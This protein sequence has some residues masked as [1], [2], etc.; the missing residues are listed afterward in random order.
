MKIDERHSSR[1]RTIAITTLGCKVNQC[2]SAAIADELQKSGYEL[3]PFNSRADCYIINTCVVTASTESQSRQ[4]IR[5]A[6][7]HS[8]SAEV[9]VTGCYAQHRAE[10]LRVLFPRIKIA[11]NAEKKDLAHTIHCLLNGGQ[12]SFDVKDIFHERIFTTPAADNIADRTRAFLKIQ[13]GCNNRC[14][15]CIVPAV[16]GP[17]RSLPAAE[18]RARML[19]LY[20]NGYHEIVLTGVHLGAWG[21]DLKPQQ[22]LSGLLKMCIHDSRVPPAWIRLS[23]IEPTEWNDELIALMTNAENL[24]PHVHIPLQSGDPGLLRSMG[25]PYTPELF[26]DLIVCLARSIPLLNTGIDVIAGLPGETDERFSNTCRLIENL[27][28]G[29][30]HVFPYSRRPGTVAAEMPGQVH[31]SVIRQR[32]RA[33]R[34]LSDLK[35]KAFYESCSGIVMDALVEG[36]RDRRTLKLRAVTR[37]YIPV[38]FDGDDSLMGT[39][40]R[41]RLEKYSQGA[42]LGLLV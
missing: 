32:T 5:R 20:A 29:Y 24:C 18:V 4:L 40:Q 41:V 17:S 33:L 13:D 23:S 2:D 12:P 1:C 39:L 6:L 19:T 3:V 22:E 14:C 30:L 21:L 9:I 15:Y 26:H 27:P 28:V 36:R 25:R 37:N 11:G 31:A 38:L 7:R 35:K 42:M 10:R 8:E 16:R 34:E